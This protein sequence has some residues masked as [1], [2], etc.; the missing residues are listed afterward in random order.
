M[1]DTVE[2]IG[3]IV[4]SPRI[5]GSGPGVGIL[6]RIEDI[7]PPIGGNVVP[8]DLEVRPVTPNISGCIG[9]FLLVQH[10]KNMAKVVEDFAHVVQVHAGTE[11]EPVPITRIPSPCITRHGV[12]IS[13]SKLC[14]GKAA[15]NFHEPNAGPPMICGRGLPESFFAS[16]VR[17]DLKVVMYLF[18]REKLFNGW[19]PVIGD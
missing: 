4:T 9:P 2:V 10:A 13:N 7:R 14:S 19:D 12:V 1:H 11:V 17:V 8:K 3:C 15:L 5:P 16:L 18:L 6:D